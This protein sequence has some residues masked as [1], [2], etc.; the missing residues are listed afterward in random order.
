[1]PGAADRFSVVVV[2]RSTG[3]GVRRAISVGRR[4]LAVRGRLLG[5]RSWRGLE[6]AFLVHLQVALQGERQLSVQPLPAEQGLDVLDRAR[7]GARGVRQDHREP[8]YAGSSQSVHLW[9]QRLERWLQLREH[10]RW[11]L[12]WIHVCAARESDEQQVRGFRR[13]LQGMPERNDVPTRR[14]RHGYEEPRRAVQQHCPVRCGGVR[15]RRDVREGSLDTAK[16]LPLQVLHQC[17][18]DLVQ[19][20]LLLR[21]RLGERMRARQRVQAA[22]RELHCELPMPRHAVQQGR[23]VQVGQVRLQSLI[24]NSPQREPRA[25]VVTWLAGVRAELATGDT[26]PSTTDCL[27]HEWRQPTLCVTLAVRRSSCAMVAGRVR[28]WAWRQRRA[29]G[30]RDFATRALRHGNAIYLRCW[31]W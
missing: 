9:Q 21:H 7:C 19:L 10:V 30:R 16:P 28:R 3:K 14:L 27:T 20:R 17:W 4:V 8:V 15:A 18:Q 6:P 25:P 1:L 26:I 2:D 29:I 31:L 5:R 13:R 24:R 23:I 11:V 12:L 22:R